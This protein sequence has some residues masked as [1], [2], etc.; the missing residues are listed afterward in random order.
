MIYMLLLFEGEKKQTKKKENNYHGEFLLF[1]FT[2]LWGLIS[3]I[4]R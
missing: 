2:I 1:C 3:S 4:V